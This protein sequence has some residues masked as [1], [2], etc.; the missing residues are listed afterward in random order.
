ME[1]QEKTVAFRLHDHV[2]QNHLEPFRSG[3]RHLPNTKT[4][5]LRIANDL[6]IA[7]DPGLLSILH[8]LSVVF[9]IISHSI[10]IHRLLCLGIPST[11]FYWFQ[12]DFLSCTQFIQHKS[13]RSQPSSF[14]SGVPQGPVFGPLLFITYFLPF[15]NVFSA[16]LCS[17]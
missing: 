1:I 2:K 13:F 4:A 16:N 9:D 7:A 15:G 5:L 3:F 12:S 14:S 17:R 10:L 6:L 11:S 8:D